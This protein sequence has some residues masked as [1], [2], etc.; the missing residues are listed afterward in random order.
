MEIHHQDGSKALIETLVFAKRTKANNIVLCYK[1][2]Q[3]EGK[4]IIVFN[5]IE[6]T[7]IMAAIKSEDAIDDVELFKKFANISPVIRG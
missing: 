3:T 4:G 7:A 5:N 1:S 2:A 6:I